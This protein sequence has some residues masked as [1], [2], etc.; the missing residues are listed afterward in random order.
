MIWIAV[1]YIYICAV[2]ID[3]FVIIPDFVIIIIEII[4]TAIITAIIDLFIHH[5]HNS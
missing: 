5:Y 4:S 2:V 1:I 3:M